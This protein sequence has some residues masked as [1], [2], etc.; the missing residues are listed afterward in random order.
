V[1]PR[2]VNATVIGFYYLA[3]FAGNAIVGWIGSFYETMPPTRFWLLHAG[4]AAAAG[5]AFVLFRLV[6]GRHLKAAR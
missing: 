1:A 2:A 3:F 5:G 6:M 4:L